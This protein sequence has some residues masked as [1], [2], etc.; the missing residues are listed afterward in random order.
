MD[1]KESRVRAPRVPEVGYLAAKA[2]HLAHTTALG[3][4][5]QG[6]TALH[7]KTDASPVYFTENL[8]RT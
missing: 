5:H 7:N 2:T 3:Y 8:K 6:L 4:C 1:V